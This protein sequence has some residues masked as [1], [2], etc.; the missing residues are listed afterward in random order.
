MCVKM[1]G[2][3]R[4]SYL[5]SMLY[6]WVCVQNVSHQDCAWA[7]IYP[8]FLSLIVLTFINVQVYILI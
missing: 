6:F 4:Y 1:W 2:V 5:L 3:H 8:T 7:A